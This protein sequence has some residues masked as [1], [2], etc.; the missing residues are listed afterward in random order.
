MSRPDEGP[1]PVSLVAL[2]CS[3]ALE[4]E[5]VEQ[6]EGFRLLRMPCSSKAEPALVLKAFEAGAQGVVLIPCP[7]GACQYMEGN[8]RARALT[9]EVV[10]LMVELG[11]EPERFSVYP[12]EPEARTGIK[13]FLDAFRQTVLALGQD[14]P[15]PRRASRHV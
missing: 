14:Q 10:G 6:V 13:G 8:R 12:L 9:Q 15:E 1:S 2:A 4:A 3:R 11:L 7:L 5:S